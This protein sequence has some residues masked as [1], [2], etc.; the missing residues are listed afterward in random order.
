[1]QSRGKVPIKG[2]GL[3]NTYFVLRECQRSI[4]LEEDPLR[5]KSETTPPPIVSQ[6]TI[7][8]KLPV[9]SNCMSVVPWK[10]PKEQN[11]CIIL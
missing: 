4:N 6:T 10:P 8:D 1:M 7:D 11:P 3:M 9:T 5:K 2:K